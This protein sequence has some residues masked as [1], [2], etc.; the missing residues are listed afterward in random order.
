MRLNFGTED[1]DGFQAAR[2][3]LVARFARWLER[4]EGAEA[5]PAGG[6]DYEDLGLLL[7]WKWG[8]QDGCLGRWTAA[9]IHEFLIDHCPRKL[10]APPEAARGIPVSVAG[11]ME[12]LEETGL[13]DGRSDSASRLAATASGLT[14]DFVEAMGD[15][16]NF[17]MA[18]SLFFHAGG[19]EDTPRDADAVEELLERVNR[20]PPEALEGL[21][22]ADA[23]AVF[24]RPMVVGPVRLPPETD[25]RASASAAPVLDRFERLR[26]FFGTKGRKLTQKGNVTLADARALVEM[27]ETGDVMDPVIGDRQFRTTSSA[28]LPGLHLYVEWAIA[29]GAI[30]RHSGRL[31]SVAAWE[32]RTKDPS[33]ALERAV[34]GLV[35]VGP[36]GSRR[37]GHYFGDLADL[38][39]DGIGRLLAEV[40]D[41]RQEAGSADIDELGRVMLGVIRSLVGGLN[42][43]AASCIEPWVRDQLD[44][45]ALAGVV[46]VTGVRVEDRDPELGVVLDK[47]RTGGTATLTPAGVHVAARLASDLGIAVTTRPDPSTATAV[48]IADLLG[49]V[50][51][52]EWLSDARAWTAGRSDKEA[53]DEL[54]PAIA[55]MERPAALVLAGL[56][57]VATLFGDAATPAVRGLLKGQHDGLAVLWLLQ[58]E[59]L[60]PA[61]V[62]SFRILSGS[63]DLFTAMLDIGGPDELT[64]AFSQ[65]QDTEQQ[66]SMLDRLWR[67]DHPRAGELL[68]ALGQHHPEKQVA[69]AARKAAFRHRSR[70]GSAG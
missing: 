19:L 25:R 16:R 29:A 69:K 22:N 1:E 66:V 7:D 31:V 27:L 5:G 10:S 63:V 53:A 24:T 39:D 23:D 44:V 37:G 8:Y 54:V 13:L 62:D 46:D 48:D 32:R 61:S 43:L 41:A 6:A 36:L 67:T 45:L 59:A 28:E 65:N 52:E 60:D 47:V 51:R 57:T 4:R 33:A 50:G 17:G 38:L 49:Q 42:P 3:G 18:K 64:K 34:D 12:F 20:L 2:D 9:D 58:Q 26:G 40:L 55:T 70:A 11:A 35:K 68:E 56:D 14:D 21:T 30:R 15:P